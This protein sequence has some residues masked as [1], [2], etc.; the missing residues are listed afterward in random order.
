[1]AGDRVEFVPIELG[2]IPLIAIVEL[3]WV[4]ELDALLHTKERVVDRADHPARR[5]QAHGAI[6]TAVEVDRALVEG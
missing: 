6:A 4:L 3:V 5:L 2:F 1:M